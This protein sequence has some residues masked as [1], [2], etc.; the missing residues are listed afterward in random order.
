MNNVVVI[1]L[2]GK[3]W[4]ARYFSRLV[5]QR[6]FECYR[7]GGGDLT[8]MDSLL[9]DLYTLER[10][11][12]PDHKMS[13]DSPELNSHPVSWANFTIYWCFVG[14]Y[15]EITYYPYFGSDSTCYYKIEFVR[16]QQKITIE[17]VEHPWLT[18]E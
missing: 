17:R 14:N 2:R 12:S 9:C 7:T 6:L 15:T 5:W 8:N 13:G 16:E 3:S 10:Y 4:S 18:T 11:F 1:D